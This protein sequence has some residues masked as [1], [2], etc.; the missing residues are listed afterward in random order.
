M[1][2]NSHE[3]EAYIYKSV[4]SAR[5]TFSPLLHGRHDFSAGFLTQARPHQLCFSLVYWRYP[6]AILI[7]IFCFFP[8]SLQANI[9]MVGHPL[10]LQSFAGHT[11]MSFNT[12]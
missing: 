4:I 7:D 12:K 1:K 9:C 5:F 3:I 11:L 8:Q 6:P 2:K 10:P